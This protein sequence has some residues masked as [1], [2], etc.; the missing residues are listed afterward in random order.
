MKNIYILLF[1]LPF[2]IKSQCGDNDFEIILE[3]TTGEWAEEM[4][5]E[6]LDSEGNE[7]LS[8]QGTDNESEY[9]DTLCLPAGC[10]ALN[11]V[12]SY[13]DGWNGGF[14]EIST[15]DSVDFEISDNPNAFIDN[16]SIF[17]GVDSGSGFYTLFQINS[18]DCQWTFVGCTD[19][20]ALNYSSNAYVDNGSCY[21]LSVKMENL[22]FL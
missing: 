21:I 15:N 7:I 14:L 6:L 18:A 22:S 3:T 12:D 2:I 1:L 9:A 13:G 17:L 4:S 5:W 16:G 19:I 10:Y 8:F 11:A 20:N